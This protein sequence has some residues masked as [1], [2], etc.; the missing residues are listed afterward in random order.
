MT[1]DTSRSAAPR[2]PSRPVDP[3]QE[4]AA[5]ASRQRLTLLE[6]SRVPAKEAP[7]GRAPSPAPARPRMPDASQGRP[8]APEA[9]AAARQAPPEDTAAKPAPSDPADR[10]EI[11]R[12]ADRAGPARPSQSPQDG[13]RARPQPGPASGPGKAPATGPVTDPAPKGRPKGK[14][15]G[16]PGPPATGPAGKAKG[17]ADGP[18]KGKASLPA[19]VAPA[20]T[21]ARNPEKPAA[22]APVPPPASLARPRRRHAL[23]AFGFLLMVLAPLAVAGWYLWTRAAD[24]YVSEM[25]FTVRRE[26]TSTPSD[27]LGG[28]ASFSSAGSSD[29]DLLYE[30]IQSQELVQ[31]IDAKLDLRAIYSQHHET[32]PLFSFDPSGSIEDLVDYWRRMVQISY[33]PGSGMLEVHAFAFEPEDARRIAQE[34]LNTSSRVINEISAVAR[35]D[36]MRYAREDLENAKAELKA[37]REALTT[38]RSRSRI[39]DPSADLQGQ[40]GLLTTLQQQLASAMIDLDLLN[41]TTSQGDPRLRQVQLRIDVIRKRIEE[42]RDKF[43]VGGSGAGGQDYATLVAEFERLTVEREFAEQ[44]YT[45]AL[46][47]FGAA[48]AEAERQSRYLA[49]YIKP[50]LAETAGYPRRALLLGLAALFLTLAWAI[51]VLVYYSLRDR[52]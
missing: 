52:Q 2:P 19:K 8:P 12:P 42:E 45:A 13:A 1:K 46:S 10:P 51:L 37:A 50:T 33:N 17:K 32:D 23:I 16:R 36:A 22:A 49:T 44:T 25:G 9:S 26:E 43:S 47:G 5:K 31:E 27:I 6:T 34:I 29:S 24:Q 48:R 4:N 21:P 28:L 7:E 35:E 14:G 38:F 41:E 30:F 15:K 39:V 20:K 11:A 40:M 18:A 3:D